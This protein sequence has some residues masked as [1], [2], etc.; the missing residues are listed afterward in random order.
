MAFT[1]AQQPTKR[2]GRAK[3]VTKREVQAAREFLRQAAAAGDVQACA[4]LVALAER[5]PVFPGGA[6]PFGDTAH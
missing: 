1:E 4:A 6:S 2:R 3:D 5:R